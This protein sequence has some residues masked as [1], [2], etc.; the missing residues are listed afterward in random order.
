MGRAREQLVQQGNRSS[1]RYG[2]DRP[3]KTTGAPSGV[4][5]GVFS[6]KLRIVR[7]TMLWMEGIAHS[8]LYQN[9]NSDI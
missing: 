4:V 6:L 3:G 8:S 5:G 9:F 1:G 7:E 2:P